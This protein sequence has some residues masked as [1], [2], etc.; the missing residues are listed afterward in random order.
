MSMRN[1]SPRIPLPRPA[2]AAIGALLIWLAVP[3]LYAQAPLQPAPLIGTAE[4]APGMLVTSSPAGAWMEAAPANQHLSAHLDP[5]RGARNG[6]WLGGIAG[7]VVGGMYYVGLNNA[8]GA[9]PWFLLIAGPAVGAA[10]G[11]AIGGTVGLI[12]K[13]TG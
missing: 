4:K 3:A 10:A 8:I 1:D 9:D 7:L 5:A 6:A 12:I 11:A 13:E 2:V